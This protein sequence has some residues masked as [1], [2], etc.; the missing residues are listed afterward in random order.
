MQRKQYGPAGVTDTTRPFSGWPTLWF[1]SYLPDPLSLGARGLR[2]V[3]LSASFWNILC[4]ARQ[5]HP[6]GWHCRHPI[7][8]YTP[9]SNAAK[10]GHPGLPAVQDPK[11]NPG[12]NDS[13]PH[14]KGRGLS[15]VNVEYRFLA[16]RLF[17][18]DGYS[19]GWGVD[20][21]SPWGGPVGPDRDCCVPR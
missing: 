9:I 14:K 5:G 1:T 21:A 7:P 8:D 12:T 16:Q 6:T 17:Y 19:P 11:A 13:T 15:W 2:F 10:H 20:S 18:Q 3:A 4:L